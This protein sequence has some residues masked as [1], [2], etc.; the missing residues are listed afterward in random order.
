MKNNWV[1]LLAL[2]IAVIALM[3]SYR[4]VPIDFKDYWGFVLGLQSLFI[5]ILIGWQIYDTIDMKKE[6]TNIRKLSVC[7]TSKIVKMD[8]AK[9]KI[10]AGINFAEGASLMQ[11]QPIT[12]YKLF[13]VSLL[14][15]MQS[16]ENNRIPSILETMDNIVKELERWYNED[17]DLV[18]D[19]VSLIMEYEKRDNMDA[20]L[21]KEV[22][23][24]LIRDKY[25]QVD[26]RMNIVIDKFKRRIIEKN[27]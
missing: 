21:K 24:P 18:E 25:E 9:L 1:S 8:K 23:Y 4:V 27:Q 6:I 13:A 26:M 22:S 3:L 5:T 20:P 7:L 10:Y 2:V 14:Y 19:E 12:A 11:L 15:C 16:Q 17:R